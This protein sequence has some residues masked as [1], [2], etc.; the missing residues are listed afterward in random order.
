[1]EIKKGIGVSKGFALGEAF[2][3]GSQDFLFRKTVDSKEVKREIERLHA[4]TNAAAKELA[5][6]SAK[7]GRAVAKVAQR[8]LESQTILLRDESLRLEIVDDIT[9]HGHSAE[10]ATSRVLKRKSKQVTESGMTEVARE[11]TNMESLLLRH[12]TGEKCEDLAHLSKKVVIVA[13]DLS[14][15]QTVGLDRSK[16]LGMLTE[17]GGRTS[18]TAIVASSL[19]IPAVVGIEE[20]A[21]DVTTGDQVI[22]DGTTGTVI[23]NPDEAT[24][25]R[26]A[27]MARNFVVAD[28]KLSHELRDLPAQTLDGVKVELLANIETPHDIQA[29][30]DHGAQGVGLYRTEFL[31]LTNKFAPTE[32]DHLEAYRKALSV[33]G[34]RPLTI[35]TLDLGADKMPVDGAPMREDNPFLG[36]RGVR[37][38]LLKP[39][40]L[41]VQFRAILKASSIGR[42]AIMV[43]MIASVDEIERV[44]EILDQVKRE[45]H[46]EGEMVDEKVPFG[47]MVEVPSAALMADKLARHVDFFSIGTNDLIAYTLAVDRSNEHVAKFYQPTHPAVLRLLKGVIEA[48]TKAGKGVS[49]CGEMSSDLVYTLLLLGMGLRT[50]SCVPK[51]IPEVKK[52][53]RSVTL[54]DAQFV[55]AKAIELGDPRATLDY[56]RME[57][58]KVLPDIG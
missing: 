13:H 8:I 23:I 47:I 43:P 44:R 3:L 16:V 24:S 54:K 17:V 45:L 50:F 29:A 15:A 14:P 28:E 48:G 19:G 36:V 37:L 57:T 40:V 2:V 35:R 42:V 38:S 32:K 5:G 55:A 11:F 26:Y 1:M 20:I 25:K 9:R 33:L 34:R 4:A 58:R 21:S 41:R 12:L 51:S 7:L 52:M 27:A 49:V 56:L 31:Y 30:L 39:D 6:A 46:R 22:L 53:I 18:H 10:Y